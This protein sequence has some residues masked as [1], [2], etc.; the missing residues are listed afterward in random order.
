MLALAPGVQAI[1][2]LGRL[3][4]GGEVVLIIEGL[5]DG[6]GGRRSRGWR[7]RA[8]W[9]VGEVR[10][11]RLAVAESRLILARLAEGGARSV[12]HP[13]VDDAEGARAVFATD[14]APLLLV[15]HHI[16]A[17]LARITDSRKR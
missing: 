15:L 8:E 13:G 10:I 9:G 17:H 11:R 3:V 4:V 2:P 5:R 16:D 1:A 14:A 7:F 12:K 6:R